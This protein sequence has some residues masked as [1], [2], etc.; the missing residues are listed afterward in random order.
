MKRIILL[1]LGVIIAR[2][3]AFVV[4]LATQP[5]AHVSIHA[6]AP[7]REVQ[8]HLEESGVWESYQMWRFTITNDGGGVAV[9][10]SNVEYREQGPFN[11]VTKDQYLSRKGKPLTHAKSATVEMLVPV[12]TNRVWRGC[13]LYHTEKSALMQKLSGL[14]KRLP[15]LWKIDSTRGLSNSFEAWHGTTNVI[16]TP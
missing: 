2:A 3:L 4:L 16:T 14:E 13:V 15:F 11:R 8:P 9:W 1:F 10:R 7:T 5:T 6:L 12:N